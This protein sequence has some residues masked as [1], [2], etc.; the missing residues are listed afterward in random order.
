MKNPTAIIE[1]AGRILYGENW[2]ARF[3]A[4]FDLST[5]TLYQIL[6]GKS[7]PFPDLLAAVETALRDHGNALDD[8]LEEFI[9]Q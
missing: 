5:K 4:D 3:C 7:E 9:D 1:R 8:L 2:K 6:K